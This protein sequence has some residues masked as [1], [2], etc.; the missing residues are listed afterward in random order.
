MV[1]EIVL[2]QTQY[3]GR[4]PSPLTEIVISSGPALPGV[5]LVF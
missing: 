5:V 3:A 1:K 4:L 2:Y